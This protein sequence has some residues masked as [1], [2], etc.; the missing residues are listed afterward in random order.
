MY[1]RQAFHT[2]ARWL[3]ATREAIAS[4]ECTSGCPSCIQSPKCGNGN[5]PLDKRA[6]IRLLTR[7]LAGA[8]ANTEGTQ[9]AGEPETGAGGP[10]E[11]GARGTG[12]DRPG[13]PGTAEGGS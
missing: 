10:G 3:G 7:L 4:C 1:K 11:P 2:A 6:A 13:T 9:R 12:P 8:P 5:D